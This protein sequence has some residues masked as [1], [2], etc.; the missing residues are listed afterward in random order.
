M[1]NEVN[2]WLLNHLKDSDHKA[3][4]TVAKINIMQNAPE[5]E[6]PEIWKSI[7]NGGIKTK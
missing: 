7:V 1:N 6:K 2:W 4:E 5:S 3:T